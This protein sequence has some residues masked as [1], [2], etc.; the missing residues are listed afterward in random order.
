M[1]A[2]LP[3]GLTTRPLTDA[4]IDDV[5]AM[6]NACEVHDS[7]RPMWE[8]ADLLSDTSGDGFDRTRDWV[9]VYE[10]D[11]PVAWAMIWQGRRTWVDV[12]PDLRGRGIGTWLRLWLERRGREV[13]SDRVGQSIDDRRAEVASMLRDAGY[14]ARH[15]SW[16][17]QMEHATAPP[18]P[19]FPEPIAIRTYRSGDEHE[20]FTMFEQAFSEFED[21]LST[22]LATWEAMTIGREGFV[23]DDLIWA[24]DGDRIV[25]GAFLI[26]P[27]DELW[28]DKFATHRDYRHR[29]IA[30]GLLHIAFRRSHE[31]GYD[32]TTLSTDS[33]TSALP[34]YERI[35]MHVTES[36]TH[37][38][39]DL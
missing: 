4:D 19:V 39:I 28:I 3:G 14:T 13:G 23:A 18:E 34:F 30:R 17:L 6:I 36:F 10:G 21:R 12:H 29:G 25:G 38:A 35:G 31:R 26:D 37:W 33:R 8:R 7:G 2:P 20:G 24:T 1:D 5:I 9:A 16:V 22:P 27:G 32:H 11:R 15:T